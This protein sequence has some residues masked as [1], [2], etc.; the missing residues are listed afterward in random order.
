MTVNSN[1]GTYLF[2]AGWRYFINYWRELFFLLSKYYLYPVKFFPLAAN[3]NLIPA[4]TAIILIHGYCRNRTD[5]WWMLRKLGQI[6]KCPIF[7]INLHPKLSSIATID[8][9]SLPQ[10]IQEVQAKTGCTQIILVGHSMGGLVASYYSEYLD[11]QDLVSAVI[12]IGSPLHGTKVSF[13][14][15]GIN[16][17]EMCPN[18]KFTIALRNRINV[19]KKAYFQVASRLDNLVYP[20]NSALLTQTPAQQQLVLPYTSHLGLLYDTAVVKQLSAWIALL[21]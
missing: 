6:T 17:K 11:E 16:A 21:R 5:W 14:G 8:E 3:T 18:S 13:A 7:T 12:T 9:Q 19:S 1:Q 20:W 4:N 2:V 10:F 15:T